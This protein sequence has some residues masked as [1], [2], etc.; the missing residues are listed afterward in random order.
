MSSFHTFTGWESVQKNQIAQWH[1]KTKVG[2]LGVRW[3]ETN[4]V[5]PS[6]TNNWYCTPKN[7]TCPVTTGPFQKDRNFRPV[8][9]CFQVTL[10]YFRL[11]DLLL[12]T[13]VLHQLIGSFSIIYKVLYI[14]YAKNLPKLQMESE[15]PTSVAQHLFVVLQNRGAGIKGTLYHS[16]VV[17]SWVGVVFTQKLASTTLGGSIFPTF[18][19]SFH[20][21]S[22]KMFN[23]KEAHN[24]TTC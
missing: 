24:T 17:S 8:V 18:C 2:H 6:F 21:F 13:Q 16:K 9:Q 22:L 20:G 12:M 23:Q 3:Q 4:K 1:L 7:L 15:S 19:W 10:V 11:I 14:P 5:Q